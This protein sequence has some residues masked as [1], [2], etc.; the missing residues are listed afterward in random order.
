ME[1]DLLKTRQAHRGVAKAASIASS[2]VV[3]VRSTAS[4]APIARTRFCIGSEL[5]RLGMCDMLSPTA[6]AR[7]C[8]PKVCCGRQYIALGKPLASNDA[9]LGHKRKI[10]D[11]AQ[12]C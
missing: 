3:N 12:A 2:G 1:E 7:R 5:P 10:S 6:A 11:S 4:S 9:P 8:T